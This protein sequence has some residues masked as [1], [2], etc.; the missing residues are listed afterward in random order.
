MNNDREPRLLTELTDSGVSPTCKVCKAHIKRWGFACL[1]GYLCV[2]C[3]DADDTK[4]ERQGERQRGKKN[5][6]RD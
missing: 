4:R 5:D 6:L 1:V 3:S 2:K